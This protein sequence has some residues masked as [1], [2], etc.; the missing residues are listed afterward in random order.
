MQK[1]MEGK[2]AEAQKLSETYGALAKDANTRKAFND[3]A[4]ELVDKAC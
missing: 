3:Q 1:I 2:A 4:L